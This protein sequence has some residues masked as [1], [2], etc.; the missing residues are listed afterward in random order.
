MKQK[1]SEKA[2]M[3]DV[4]NVV[5]RLHGHRIGVLQVWKPNQV[6]PDPKDAFYRKTVQVEKV[7]CLACGATLEEIRGE[8]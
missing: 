5:C 1:L 8:E 6:P 3:E 7:L 4:A 2:K